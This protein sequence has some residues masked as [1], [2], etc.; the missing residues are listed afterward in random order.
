MIHALLA[1]TL[2]VGAVS[3]AKAP[4]DNAARQDALVT[5][6]RPLTPSVQDDRQ[7]AVTY[8]DD[9]LSLLQLAYKHLTN[10]QRSLARAE[11][12]SASGKLSTAQLIL[13]KDRAFTRALAPLSV[14]AEQVYQ[15]ANG[16][17]EHTRALVSALQHDLRPLYREQVAHLGGGAGKALED[18]DQL[19]R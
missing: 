15:G 8:L 17:L 1:A 13:Y 9:S 4:A 14:R 2:A 11:L 19:R 10:G 16:D 7:A 5:V 12:M 6:V 3:P 18:L